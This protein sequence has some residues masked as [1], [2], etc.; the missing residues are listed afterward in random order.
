MEL[1]MDMDVVQTRKGMKV[2]TDLNNTNVEQDKLCDPSLD[3]AHV[4]SLSTGQRLTL[5]R[6]LQKNI[7]NH[8]RITMKGSKMS[9]LKLREIDSRF[10]PEYRDLPKKYNERKGHDPVLFDSLS[11]GIKN[12]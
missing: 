3:I 11:F 6:N 9:L 5:E 10:F 8:V 2:I 1:Y 12:H 7:G 4:F